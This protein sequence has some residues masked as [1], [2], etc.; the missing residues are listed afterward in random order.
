VTRAR[1]LPALALVALVAVGLVGGYLLG[2]NSVPDGAEAAA[3]EVAASGDATDVAFGES[4]T[5]GV[6]QGIRQ[7]QQDAWQDGFEAGMGKGKKAG[8]VAA[9]RARSNPVQVSDTNRD[10]ASLGPAS[11][12]GD[13]G[14]LVVGD[15]LEVLTS[16]YLKQYM[17][18]GTKL[19][20]NAE[21]GY[22]SLQIYDLFKESYDPSQSVIVFD[23]GTND[24]PAYPSILQG[25]LDAVASEVGDRCMV[26]PTIHGFTVD[27]VDNTGKNR[28]V[29]SFAASRPGTQTP[30][31]AGWVASHQDLMADELHPNPEGSD[32]RAQLIAEGVR[33]CLAGAA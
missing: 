27:G 24:N 21:G 29:R 8:L 25:R 13:G 33:A 11:L 15:S 1:L 30:D 9:R 19:T 20:V 28:V 12:P 18:A 26:V 14:V 22:N 16:P 23:A 17:P 31:W 6:V 5:N 3:A 7:A 2:H 32:Q 10:R 4:L